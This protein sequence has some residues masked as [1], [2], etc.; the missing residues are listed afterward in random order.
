MKTFFVWLSLATS[1]AFGQY[2]MDTA[3]APPADLSPAFAALLQQQGVKILA[4]SGSVYCE[5]WLRVKAPSGPKSTDD[6]VALP[7]IP[8]GALLGVIRFTGA[9]QDRRGQ[10]ITRALRRK[11]I[12]P[13]WCR[14]A[15]I[16]TRA[17]RRPSMPW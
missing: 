12:S 3:G 5:L 16:P 13:C 10:P 4:A 6:G 8:Q 15:R 11:G 2:K 7:T 9:A 1:I 14:S 17:P